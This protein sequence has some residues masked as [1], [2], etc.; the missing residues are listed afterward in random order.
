MINFIIIILLK[1]FLFLNTNFNNYKKTYKSQILGKK[2]SN[3]VKQ[4]RK[5][6]QKIN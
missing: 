6:D 2:I 3:L 1:L 4:L 5:N